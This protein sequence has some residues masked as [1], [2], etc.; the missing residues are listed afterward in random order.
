MHITK[1]ELRNLISEALEVILTN[2]EAIEMFGDEIAPKLAESD[3]V[4]SAEISKLVKK[5]K[6]QKQAVAM[7]LSMDEE[8]KDQLDE[9]DM[10]SAPDIDLGD[11][12]I[13][14]KLQQIVDGIDE[15]N[16]RLEDIDTSIDYA[17]AGILGDDPD[18]VQLTQ[19]LGGRI[20]EG[21][22]ITREALEALAKGVLKEEWVLRWS[23]HGQEFFK[24]DGEYGSR[25]DA[26]KFD[27]E[28]AAKVKAKNVKEHGDG[29]HLIP[30]EL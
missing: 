10:E 25:S 28:A 7:A 29:Y 16:R 27:S 2:S 6:S 14:Q 9:H 12:E 18:A 17:A 23:G 15:T 21:D 13:L 24:G 11:S 19:K 20:T 26:E 5:G 1:R 4:V 30:E 8:G 22:K 3:D